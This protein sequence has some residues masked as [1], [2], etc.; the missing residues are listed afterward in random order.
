M[1]VDPDSVITSNKRSRGGQPVSISSVGDSNYT[2]WFAPTGMTSSSNFM[3]GTTMRLPSFSPTLPMPIVT[4]A[5]PQ[6]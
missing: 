2:V 4:L 6:Q 5:I 3:A 1:S